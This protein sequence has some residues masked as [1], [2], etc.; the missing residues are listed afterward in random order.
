MRGQPSMH[1]SLRF[2]ILGIRR[3]FRGVQWFNENKGTDPE[4]GAIF[5]N[6]LEP[7]ALDLQKF[8]ARF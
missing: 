3:T 5:D 2:V 7:K 8:T 6:A 4:T 1:R